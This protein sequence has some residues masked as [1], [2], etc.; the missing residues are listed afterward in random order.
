M[1]CSP[2]RAW[3]GP[4]VPLIGVT[5]NP[6]DLR[7]L[8][9]G[10]SAVGVSAV[11]ANDKLFLRWLGR[12]AL[13][14]GGGKGVCSSRGGEELILGGVWLRQLLLIGAGDGVSVGGETSAR[15]VGVGG[16]GEWLSSKFCA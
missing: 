2:S 5:G 8:V 7:P 14:D 6:A 16:G 1:G 3:P 11:L 10:A 12:N 4:N 15:N 13:A 9:F